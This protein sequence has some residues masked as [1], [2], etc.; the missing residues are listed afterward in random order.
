MEK[1]TILVVE[2]DFELLKSNSLLLQNEGYDILAAETLAAAMVHLCKA[3]PDAVILDIMLP[4]GSGLEFLKEVRK[5]SSI[6]ILL[7]TSL[8][9]NTDIIKGLEA[10]GDDYLSKPFD[11]DVFLTRVKVMLR[12]TAHLPETLSKGSLKLSPYSGQAFFNGKDLLVSQK[13]FALLLVFMQSEG[14]ML[15]AD[16]L[17][18]KVW[19]EPMAEDANALRFQISRLRKKLACSDYTI[20]AEYGGGYCFEKA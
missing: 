7:L 13:E 2:D 15:A 18:K 14:Q 5:I 17:Y 10:G 19:G 6:P 3:A 12:R 9:T 16:F 20:T 11:V 8:S 4:D 1:K